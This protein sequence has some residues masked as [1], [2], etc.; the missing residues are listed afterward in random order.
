[1]TDKSLGSTAY[2]HYTFTLARPP[3]N[4]FYHFWIIYFVSPSTRTYPLF[5]LILYPLKPILYLC[6]QFFP[7]LSHMF[8][9]QPSTWTALLPT[10]RHRSFALT[11]YAG[12][13]SSSSSEM[14]LYSPVWF[15]PMMLS[16]YAQ[17]S[18]TVNPIIAHEK[19]KYL[20]QTQEQ[21]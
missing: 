21:S 4:F 16:N 2:L 20:Y 11:S 6:N 8:A 18:T 14:C 13:Q 9:K 12:H 7:L 3:H 1:M 10:H 15:P 19:L 5:P 17:I